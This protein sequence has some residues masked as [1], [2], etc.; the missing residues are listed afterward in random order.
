M[1]KGIYFFILAAGVF[2]LGPNV[3]ASDIYICLNE[4]SEDVIL[5]DDRGHCI[6]GEKEIVLMGVKN[7][8]ADSIVLV[9]SFSP[10]E[11]CK[12]AERKTAKVGI[13]KNGNNVLD[14]DEL[15]MVSQECPL[16]PEE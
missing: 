15:I 1:S 13:D 9:S 4:T 5:M 10:N 11:N 6:E 3:Y 2:L 16:E 8:P 12:T 7:V 14:D